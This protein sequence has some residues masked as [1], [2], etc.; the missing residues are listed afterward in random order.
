MPDKSLFAAIVIAG[1]FLDILVG[2]PENSYHPIRF[3]GNL[4]WAIEKK[5]Y[6]KKEKANLKFRGLCLLVLSTSMVY[7]VFKIS[8]EIFRKEE[9]LYLIYGTLFFYFGICLRE[10]NKRGLEIAELVDKNRLENAREK[11]QMIVGRDTHNLDEQ[12]I[13]RATTE[14]IS[15]NL[16]DGIIAPMFFFM[17]GGIPLM[18]LYKTVNTLDSMVGYKNENYKHFGYFSA[19]ADDIL[20]F[21]PAR[22]T[23]FLI[24]LVTMKRDVLISIKKFARAHPS[25]NSGFPEA[26]MAG[27]IGCRFGGASTYGGVTIIKPFIGK[28]SNN[29]TSSEIKKVSHINL[30]VSI[31]FIIIICMKIYFV[32]MA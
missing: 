30:K 19:K 13:L 18:Y 11:L 21:I 22:I 4:I 23:A 8:E 27:A 5:T 25:P 20:N 7:F 3:I 24:F 9:C 2:D 15:E 16:N 10:L 28:G 26:A 6:P 31:L 14:T 12:S 29:I 32:D 17:L 1:F